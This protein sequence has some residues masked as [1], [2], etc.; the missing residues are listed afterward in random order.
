ML[1]IIFFNARRT[2]FLKVLNLNNAL[3]GIKINFIIIK[4]L[5]ILLPSLINIIFYCQYYMTSASLVPV[6]L[7]LN[8]S[9][10]TSLSIFPVAAAVKSYH[11]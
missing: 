4:G 11:H 3:V 1:F 2:K 7:E 9:I 5:I 10:S 6:S 8:L